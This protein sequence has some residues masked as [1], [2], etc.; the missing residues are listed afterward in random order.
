MGYYL[1]VLTPEERPIA[2]GILTKAVARF[3]CRIRGDTQSGEWGVIEVLNRSGETLCLVERNPVVLGSVGEDEI[4]VFQEE[5]ADCLPKAAAE[6]LRVYLASVRTIYAIQV[7]DA[8]DSDDGGAAL[9]D[10]EGA[11]WNAAGGIFQADGE[12]FSNED[13][14]HILW[15]FS[16]RV[17]GEWWG[18]VLKA[19]KWERFKMDLGSEAHRS[20]FKSGEIPTGAER[21]R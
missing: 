10:V 19:G 3:G 12:G 15:Q 1:R 21:A 5:I 16:D 20:A 8:V 13:G 18:A 7:F 11:I 17:E 4:S 2:P 9:W 14:D 6:W